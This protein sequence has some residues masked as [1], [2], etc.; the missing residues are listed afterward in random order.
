MRILETFRAS[1]GLRRR[2]GVSNRGGNPKGGHQA[3]R[4]GRQ[5]T[6]EVMH[7]MVGIRRPPG[8]FGDRT[9]L[10]LKQTDERM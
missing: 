9:K 8:S 3:R 2:G 1:C 6:E 4:G 5:G 10:L 7:R